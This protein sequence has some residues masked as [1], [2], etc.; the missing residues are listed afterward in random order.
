VILNQSIP[1][2]LDAIKRRVQQ[3]GR[4]ISKPGSSV[5]TWEFCGIKATMGDGGYSVQIS[6]DKLSVW[7]EHGSGNSGFMQGTLL[8]LR[9]LLTELGIAAQ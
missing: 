9:N 4:L 1:D 8:D 6:T 7:G 2:Q 3:D 5:D